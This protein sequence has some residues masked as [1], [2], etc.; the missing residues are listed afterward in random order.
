MGLF[1]FGV[2]LDHADLFARSGLGVALFLHSAFIVGDQA[3]GRAHDILGGAVV[4]LQPELLRFGIVFLEPEDVLD[5]RSAESVDALGIVAHHAD[6]VVRFGQPAQDHILRV[7]RVLVLVDEDVAEAGGNGR[8]RL[9]KPF[10]QDVRVEQ[11]V[12]EVHRTGFPAFFLVQLVDVGHPRPAGGAVGLRDLGIGPVASHSQQAVL[13][14]GDDALDQARLVVLLVQFQ[15]L[16]ALLENAA[17]IGL[18]VDGKVFGIAEQVGVLPKETDENRMERAH[19]D[20][21]GLLRSHQERDALLHLPG[22]LLGKSQGQYFSGP[23]VS[24]QYVRNPAGKHPGLSGTG[25]RDD[26]RRPFRAQDSG[27]L[28]AVQPLEQ[29]GVHVKSICNLSKFNVQSYKSRP[30]NP[31]SRIRRE[32]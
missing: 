18:V 32:G 19:L 22:G 31:W 25:P 21:A 4:L 29:V 1:A 3:V 2:G 20:P 27:F 30:H 5:P 9:R 10:E 14:F 15:F 26:E 24:F 13:G 6:V 8:A 23:A 16:D 12:V 7:V 17:G 28:R 11:D